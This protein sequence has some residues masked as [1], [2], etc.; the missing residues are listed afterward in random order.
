MLKETRD[1]LFGNDRYEGFAIDII[2]ELAKIEGFNYTFEVGG[3]TGAKDKGPGKWTGMR[4]QI[5]DGVS[6]PSVNPRN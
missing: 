5:I 1:Q 3:T 6:I 4:G 2:E